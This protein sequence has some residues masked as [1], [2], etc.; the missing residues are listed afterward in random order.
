MATSRV[1]RQPGAAASLLHSSGGSAVKTRFDHQHSACTHQ[2]VLATSPSAYL[3]KDHRTL[4]SE[5]VPAFSGRTLP[6]SHRPSLKQPRRQSLRPCAALQK[7]GSP[8][9]PEE[10]IIGSLVGHLGLNEKEARA[11][12]GAMLDGVSQVMEKEYGN[13]EAQKFSSAFP[14]LTD[15]KATARDILMGDTHGSSRQSG[16]GLGDVLGDI[17]GGR[18]EPKKK[19]GGDI[20]GDIFGGGGDKRSRSSGGGLGG[21]LGDILGDVVGGDGNDRRNGG[22]YEEERRPKYDTRYEEDRRDDRYEEE[23]R[24]RSEKKSGGWLR[25]G[26]ASTVGHLLLKSFL[27]IGELKLAV[28]II[29]KLGVDPVQTMAIAYLLIKFVRGRVGPDIFGMVL[30]KIPLFRLVLDDRNPIVRTVLGALKTAILR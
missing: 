29:K 9:A 22:G 7:S 25:G 21:K 10:D 12:T 11:L 8:P 1:L 28:N 6:G 26:V 4:P 16:G 23:E 3:T 30:D 13:S 15:W 5:E 20:L 14:D 2:P 17:L 27:G 24:R 18:E 19:S